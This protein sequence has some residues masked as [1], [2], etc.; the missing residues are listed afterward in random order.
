MPLSIDRTPA[1]GRAGLPV[2]HMPSVRAFMTFARVCL[3]VV[4]SAVGTEAGAVDSSVQPAAPRAEQQ[5][6]R[7][8]EM[9]R[10]GDPD[11]ALRTLDPLLAA[12]PANLRALRLLA[13][14]LEADG[15]LPRELA[16]RARLARDDPERGTAAAAYARALERDGS[17]GAALEQ[18]REA[19]RIA[20]SHDLD[21]AIDRMRLRLSPEV[22]ASVAVETDTRARLTRWHAGVALP[23]GDRLHL[24]IA[25]HRD[26]ARGGVLEETE[27]SS[28]TALLVTAW[29]TFDFEAGLTV[30][31]LAVGPSGAGGT[32]SIVSPTLAWR[33]RARHFL[34]ELGG[35]L[36]A[37]WT[38]VPTSASEGGLVDEGTLMLF[39][40]TRNGRLVPSLSV[41]LRR[42][43]LGRSQT[44]EDPTARQGLAIGGVDWV[45]WSRPRRTLRGEILDERMASA[46]YLADAWTI[47]YRH[48]E[49]ASR[50][51]PTFAARLALA[52]RGS[53][54]EIS[55][56]ARKV[57]GNGHLGVEI[58][59]GMGRDW[60]REVA[61]VRLGA[62]FLVATTRASRLSLSYETAAESA[63]AIGGR[64]E[65]LW[66]SCHV[67]L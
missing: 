8:E 20:P 2:A 28:L 11:G 5:L 57:L 15:D 23:I 58:Q 54:D 31:E 53:S 27:M 38:E 33:R 60:V 17:L 21:E 66:A 34:L 49:M 41:D 43:H 3:T 35:T 44:D 37:P 52:G 39:A 64:R 56:V 6:T 18:Y 46:T 12:E 48:A 32:T 30:G 14:A 42:M 16:V 22:A 40:P 62:R 45:L 10:I 7:A 47:G 1:A 50:S 65:T 25:A 26:T 55:T 36:R 63:T 4:I 19:R 59:G 29:R 24:S 61:W 51:E 13:W 67:D 9:M